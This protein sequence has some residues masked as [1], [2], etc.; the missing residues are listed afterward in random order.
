[1]APLTIEATKADEE[2]AQVQRDLFA[3]SALK[4]AGEVSR[5]RW[6]ASVLLGICFVV[7]GLVIYIVRQISSALRHVAAEMTDSAKQ[8]T[9]ASGEVSS[10]SQAQPPAPRRK[11]VKSIGARERT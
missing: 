2:L 10:S 9:S 7:G 4:A 11:V 6:I 5:S 1:M 3:A 8:V